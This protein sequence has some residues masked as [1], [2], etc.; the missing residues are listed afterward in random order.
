MTFGEIIYGLIRKNRENDY[1][2]VLDK[3]GRK[4]TFDQARYLTKEK[5]N[6]APAKMIKEDWDKTAY[7][8]Y[9]CDNR[10]DVTIQLL[11]DY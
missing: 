5:F 10:W 7:D 2:T 11:I 4:V 8:R 6:Y 9:I 3:R 1:I